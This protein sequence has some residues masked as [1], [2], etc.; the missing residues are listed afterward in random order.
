MG[1]QAE[2][3]KDNLNISSENNDLGFNSIQ[4]INF[5]KISH[6]IALGS[7]SDLGHG[8]HVTKAI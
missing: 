5:K 2:S 3:L 7:K 6:L 1:L 4:K 8:G